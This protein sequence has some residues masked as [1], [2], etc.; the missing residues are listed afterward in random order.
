TPACAAKVRATPRP[1]RASPSASPSSFSSAC[2]DERMDELIHALTRYG[3]PLV[4]LNILLQQLGLPIPAVPTLIVAGALAAE[5]RLSGAGVLA[6]A[7][8]AAVIA[9]AVWY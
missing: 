2:S 3:V 5:G 1:P 4:F 8:L 6:A 9:D 7:F